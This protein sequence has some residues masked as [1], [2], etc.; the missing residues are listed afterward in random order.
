MIMGYTIVKVPFSSKEILGTPRKPKYLIKGDA[1]YIFEKQNNAYV[2][3][4]QLAKIYDEFTYRPNDPAMKKPTSFYSNNSKDRKDIFSHSKIS[5]EV[6]KASKDE[7]NKL[8]KYILDNATTLKNINGMITGSNTSG[9]ETNHNVCPFRIYDKKNPKYNYLRFENAFNNFK[10]S[11]VLSTSPK[12]T[13]EELEN[14]SITIKEFIKLFPPFAK[15]LYFYNSDVI[16]PEELGADDNI[17]EIFNIAVDKLPKLNDKVQYYKDVSHEIVKRYSERTHFEETPKLKKCIQKLRSNFKNGLK[18]EALKNNMKEDYINEGIPIDVCEGAH[19]VAVA[20]I[21]KEMK[22]SELLM[23]S[24]PNNGIL[25]SP[26]AHTYMDKGYL[27]FDQ[28]NGEPIFKRKTLNIGR[29]KKIILN[30]ERK[31]FLKLRNKKYKY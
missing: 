27:S 11:R 19:L 17:K 25:V 9:C 21:K 3:V 18:L 15:E 7:T 22:E 10:K 8:N 28:N 16:S 23:I 26:T 29:L 20:D 2:N 6:K 24:N 13:F 4:R 1:Y 31:S 14:K 30:D 12:F 5:K